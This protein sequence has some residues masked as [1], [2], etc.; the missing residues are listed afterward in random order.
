MKKFLSILLA[1]LLL[2]CPALAEEE[3]WYLETAKELALSM[4]ELAKDEAYLASMTSA[5]FDC[6]EP[7]KAADYENIVSAW[8]YAVPPV[9]GVLALLGAAEGAKMS[10]TAMDYL[11][12]RFAATIPTLYN[13]SFGSQEGLAAATMLSYSRSFSI[14][15]SFD[16]CIITLELDKGAIAVS[17]SQTGDDTI[18]ATACPLFGPADASPAD[19]V[20]D[21]N[22]AFPV[23]V[24]NQ[25][26]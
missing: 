6:L 26:F 16:P 10:R 4:G 3:N 14:P 15:E 25:L 17:F 22:R 13:T 8:I 23:I 5:S 19:M 21:L 11:N 9:D 18:T 24:A 12:T 7:L 20:Q 2:A 1:I